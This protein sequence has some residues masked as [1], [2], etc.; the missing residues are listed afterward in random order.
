MKQFI[1]IAVFG[2]SMT[3]MPAGAEACRFRRPPPPMIP[4]PYDALVV[5]TAPADI[6][7]PPG[8][9]GE[10]WPEFRIIETLD[11]IVRGTTIQIRQELPPPD[12]NGDVRITVGGCIPPAADTIWPGQ[13]IQAGQRV[14]AV[15]RRE[16][17]VDR[18]ISW[19]PLDQAM[20]AEPF[21]ALYLGTRVPAERRKLADHWREGR[22]RRGR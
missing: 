22:G 2:L 8:A 7:P 1:A 17:G 3:I 21:V 16:Q 11:G 5:A 15:V 20:R 6:V 18:V 14:L 12:E 13:A 4:E 10:R 19:T 9:R